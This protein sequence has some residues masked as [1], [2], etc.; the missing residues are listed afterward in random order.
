MSYGNIIK[1]RLSIL[2]RQFKN[3][4]IFSTQELLLFNKTSRHTLETQLSDWVK[5]NEIVK[6]KKGLYCFNPKTSEV[7]INNFLISNRLYEP[8]YISLE[9]ALSFYGLIPD[10]AFQI[11]SITTNKTKKFDNKLGVFI[12]R[13]IKPA[14]FF[15]FHQEKI[16][17]NL[18]LIA[19]KEKALIDYLYIN[20]NKFKPEM[21]YLKEMRLQNINTLRQT[22]LNLYARATHKRKIMQ[23][24]E[25]LK[26]YDE[27]D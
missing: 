24:I 7:N 1:M 22:K 27:L 16:N 11:T 5:K 9:Y 2:K 20:S 15:G 8:S 17:N 26:T 6:L 18:I 10:V 21:K 12:Y 4:P 25:L 19:D 23:I 13:H 14:L 3:F